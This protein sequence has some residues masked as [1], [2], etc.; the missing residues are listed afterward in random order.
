[1]TELA[2]AP[3]VALAVGTGAP[4]VAAGPLT[5]PPAGAKLRR[6]PLYAGHQITW[7][8]ERYER[9]YAMLAT[10][11]MQTDAPASAVAGQDAAIETLTRQR[12]LL[13]LPERW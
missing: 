3:A 2:G 1:M 5:A 4:G 9:E 11:P 10:Y 7:P 8:S 13:D 12:V 6:N